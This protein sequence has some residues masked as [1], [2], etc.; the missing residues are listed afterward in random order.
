[1]PWAEEEEE[2]EEEE[3]VAIDMSTCCDMVAHCVF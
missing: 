2:E 3:E 1:L